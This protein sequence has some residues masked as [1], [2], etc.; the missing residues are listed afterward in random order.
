[1]VDQVI[2]LFFSA[3]VASKLQLMVGDALDSLDDLRRKSHE[4]TFDF[5]YIDADKG[6]SK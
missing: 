1:M 4:G 2:K 5:C 3:G 6:R